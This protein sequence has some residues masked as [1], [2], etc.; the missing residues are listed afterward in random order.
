MGELPVI[1]E[2][3]GG[4]LVFRSSYGAWMILTN[5]M[6][7]WQTEVAPRKRIGQECHP[8]LWS[9]RDATTPARLPR[10]GPRLSPLWPAAR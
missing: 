1:C 7:L 2:G 6:N 4:E 9:A 10:Q 5:F 3:G 8:T